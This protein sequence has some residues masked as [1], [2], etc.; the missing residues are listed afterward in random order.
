M[1]MEISHSSQS[2]NS[3]PQKEVPAGLLAG[4][5]LVQPVQA[6]DSKS[7]ACE[8]LRGEKAAVQHKSKCGYWA[9]WPQRT[10]AGR[11][12]HCWSWRVLTLPCF[13]VT[14]QRSAGWDD[15]F[16]FTDCQEL[17]WRNKNCCVCLSGGI[18]SLFTGG[19]NHLP[20]SPTLCLHP[21]V[22]WRG[23]AYMTA[24]WGSEGFFCLS[25]ILD[26]FYSSPHPRLGWWVLVL[27]F[28]HSPSSAKALTFC[29]PPES[30]T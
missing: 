20:F 3:C 2:E 4:W 25:A 24:L 12:E 17:C 29:S 10:R 8:S 9:I 14:V 23:P 30:V 6:G 5:L 22:L 21:S 19:R 7:P 27:Q 18:S 15:F 13:G 16:L 11:A 28:L 1:S 26:P